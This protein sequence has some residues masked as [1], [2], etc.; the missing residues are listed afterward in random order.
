M[1]PR[2]NCCEVG[3]GPWTNNSA[4]F[5]DNQDQDRCVKIKCTA[6]GMSQEQDYLLLELEVASLDRCSRC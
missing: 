2:W 4:E 6:R 3:V 5:F 1:C